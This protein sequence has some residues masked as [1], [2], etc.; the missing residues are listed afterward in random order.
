[1]KLRLTNRE[2]GSPINV[3]CAS[4]EI[5]GGQIITTSKGGDKFAYSVSQYSCELVPSFVDK[6]RDKVRELSV[7]LLDV[8][9]YDK[10]L[11]YLVDTL[12]LI[13]GVRTE[14]EREEYLWY[15]LRHSKK[16]SDT[17]IQAILEVITE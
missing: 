17:E 4:F 6:V 7:P 13:E 8:E 9:T 12:C 15:L 3:D 14:D 5:K 10:V 11:L 1:M 2:T 16:F